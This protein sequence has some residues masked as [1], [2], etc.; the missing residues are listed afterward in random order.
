MDEGRQ[1][2]IEHAE[3]GESNARPIHEERTHKICQD[4]S[5]ASA[6]NPYRFY[7]LEQVI[8]EKHD[9]GTLARHIGS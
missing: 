2:R 7:E 6:R 5:P 8:A 4:D 1:Q 9:V 3:R